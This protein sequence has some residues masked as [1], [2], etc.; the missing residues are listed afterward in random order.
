MPGQIQVTK[1]MLV[2]LRDTVEAFSFGPWPWS[3]MYCRPTP[4]FPRRTDLPFDQWKENLDRVI[5]QFSDKSDDFVIGTLPDSPLF[6]SVM[7]ELE[8]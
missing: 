7:H 6:W 1:K 2:D 8:E 3:M 4:D 5:K